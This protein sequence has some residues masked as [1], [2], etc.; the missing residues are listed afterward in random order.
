MFDDE[1]SQDYLKKIDD[2]I[3]FYKEFQDFNEKIKTKTVKE[4]REIIHKSKSYL[5]SISQLLDYKKWM[6]QFDKKTKVCLD[7]LLRMPVQEWKQLKLEVELLGLK[8][9]SKIYEFICD[10]IKHAEEF[11]AN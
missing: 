10:T 4:A 2:Q 1:Q 11:M 5:I 6:N 8:F 9:R 7:P 3:E